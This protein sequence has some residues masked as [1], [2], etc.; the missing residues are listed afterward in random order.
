MDERAGGSQRASSTGAGCHELD[1]IGFEGLGSVARRAQ[2]NL[3]R[4]GLARRVKIRQQELKDLAMD[5]D[6]DTGLVVCNP[7]YGERMG[8]EA[9]LVYLY[10]HLGEKLKQNCPGWEAGIFTGTASLVK[11]SNGTKKE[12]FTL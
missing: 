3:E 9:S 12:L 10:K 2:S 6:V 8:D 11:I 4:V 1:I 7:P 5:S